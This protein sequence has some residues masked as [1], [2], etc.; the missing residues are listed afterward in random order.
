[1]A[2]HPSCPHY[3]KTP[4]LGQNSTHIDLFCDCH[5]FDKPIVLK[6]GTDVAWP[7]GWDEERADEWRRKNNLAYQSEPGSGP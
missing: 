1:M 6:N 5:K 4:P 2:H 7:A 3:E